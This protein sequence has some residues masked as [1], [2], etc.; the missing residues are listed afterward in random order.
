MRED[1]Y[2]AELAAKVNHSSS[3][4]PQHRLVKSCALLDIEADE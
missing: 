4:L 3:G 1:V 2:D